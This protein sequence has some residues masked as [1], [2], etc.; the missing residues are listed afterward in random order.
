[1]KSQYHNWLMQTGQEEKAGDVAL[2]IAKD[3]ETAVKCFMNGGMPFK[4]AGVIALHENAAFR[5]GLLE[6]VAE[7][8]TACGLHEKAGDIYQRLGETKNAVLAYRKGSAFKKAVEL[9]REVRPSDVVEIEEEWG[10]WLLGRHEPDAALNHF[11]EAACSRKAVEAALKAKQWKRALECLQDL[12]A[13]EGEDTARPYLLDLAKTFTAMGSLSEAERCFCQAGCSKD[14][15]VM[16]VEAGFL[17]R[18]LKLA[19]ERLSAAERRVVVMEIAQNLE[20]RRKL[21]E[22][23]KAYLSIEEYDD[24]IAMHRRNGQVEEMLQRVSLYRPDLL[25]ATHRTLG[26]EMEAAGNLDEAEQFYTRGG[27]WRLAVGMYRQL[28]KWDA[29]ARVARKEGEAAHNEVIRALAQET[30]AAEGLSAA[31]QLLLQHQFP[32]DAVKLALDAEDFPLALHIAE[33]SAE[34]MLEAV[35]LQ[36]ATVHEEKGDCC[37]AEKHFVRAGRATEA[38][39]MYRHLGAW[40]DAI[41]VASAHAPDTVSD[42]LV[43]QAKSLAS[44]DDTKGAERLFVEAERPD[45]AVNM[46]LSKCMQTEAMA[47]SR[48]HCPQLLPELVKRTACAEG[49]P[50]TAAELIELANAFEAAGEVDAA[51]DVCCSAT[52]AMVPDNSLLNKIW[53]TAVKLAETKAAHRVKGIS[54]EVARKMIDASGPSLDVARLFQAAGRA[55]EA[56]KCLVA[57]EEWEKARELAA[58]VAP[59]C[60]PFVDEARRQKLISARDIATLLAIGDG[61]A[62]I[63]VA[64]EEGTWDASLSLAKE[65]APG[66][67]PQIVNAYCRALIREKREDEAA[68]I[69]LHSATTLSSEGRLLICE[70][71][72][73]LYS[74]LHA[75]DEDRA[76]CL[77]LVKRLLM[78]LFSSTRGEREGEQN[79]GLALSIGRVQREADRAEENEEK[80]RRVLLLVSHYLSVLDI[81]GKH[82]QEDV[83]E[84]AAKT[85]VAILRHAKEFRSDEAFYRAGQHCRKAGWTGMAFFFLNRYLDIADAIDEPGGTSLA[86]SDFELTDIPAPEELRIPETHSL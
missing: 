33:T 2:R 54:A 41:R 76:R 6:S 48:E 64:A 18:G 70:L 11:L 53:L 24:V 22:A 85:A 39:E 37:T 38:I 44:E 50:K 61:P 19:S 14:A 52:S 57:C 28:G 29:A 68:N 59:E 60:L 65:C 72:Q 42:L 63:Q 40:E 34:H 46:Y 75:S 58:A 49:G 12:I 69:F 7:A 26:E 80:H 45:L 16:Y 27:L 15:V 9:S 36:M 66:V 43:C 73:S 20:E 84:A 25:E 55:A 47:V 5:P 86:S 56:V 79:E 21:E 4:A 77:P 74:S 82:I 32:E 10:D 13:T 17:D 83:K 31:C 51:I 67:V 30:V 62:A 78:K 3:P 81:A 23:E 35:N 8:L 71:A 1:M